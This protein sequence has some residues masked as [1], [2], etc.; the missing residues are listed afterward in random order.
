LRD[1]V[2]DYATGGTLLDAADNDG[3][4]AVAAV[5]ATCMSQIRFTDNLKHKDLNSIQGL[6]SEWHDPTVS[7][8]GHAIS[9]IIHNS[10]PPDL[11]RRPD[12]LDITSAGRKLVAAYCFQKLQV[13]RKK[14]E[15]SPEMR[16]DP[17]KPWDDWDDMFELA[18]RA[19]SVS[20]EKEDDDDPFAE[21]LIN[22]QASLRSKQ[23]SGR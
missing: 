7:L 2:T 12:L 23:S 6:L 17:D 14:Y 18:T 4:Q 16:N 11:H 22:F 13:I 1:L 19:P 20:P 9:T 8:E 10:Y 3:R 21:Y 15:L 5:F